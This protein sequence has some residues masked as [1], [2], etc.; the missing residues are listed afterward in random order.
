VQPLSF[1]VATADHQVEAYV[2]GWDD[3]RD[4]WERERGLDR[5]GRATDFW[6]YFSDDITKARELGCRHFRLSLSWSRL[7][8]TPG[9]YCPE[10]VA[11]Y[12][13]ILEHIREQG[14][15]PIVTLLH[16]TWPRH[17]E[18]RGGL[19][20][21]GFPLLFAAF[22]TKIAQ[23][24]ARLVRLWVT[25]NEPTQLVYG[26]IKPAFEAEYAAPPG[27][28]P[29][30]SGDEQALQVSSLIRNLFCAHK[31]AREAIRKVRPS[32][33]VGANPLVLGMPG[34]IRWLGECRVQR[35]Q[36]PERVRTHLARIGTRRLSAG[37]RLDIVLGAYTR[38]HDREREVAFSE[39]Y[40]IA[41]RRILVRR[42]DEQSEP[43]KRK[44]APIA[45]L[46]G[47]T[48]E[49]YLERSMP[50]V[51]GVRFA[52]AFSALEALRKGK[53]DG[54][55]SDDVL[56]APYVR[57][58]PFELSRELLGPE[59][60]CVA[61]AKRHSDLLMPI[62]RVLHARKEALGHPCEESHPTYVGTRPRSENPVTDSLRKLR[63]RGYLRVGLS[64]ARSELYER[65]ESRHW[66]GC[67]PDLARALAKEL[68]G[69]N[70]TVRFKQR[71]IRQRARSLRP[72]WIRALD[73]L[74]NYYVLF[75]LIAADWWSMGMAGELPESLCPI[76]CR[77]EQDYAGLDYYWGIA[78]PWPT[79]VG[80]LLDAARGHFSRAPVWPGGLAHVL[81]RLASRFPDKPIYV[82][83]NGCVDRADGVARESYLRS[84]IDQVRRARAK[85]I[86]VTIYTC[87][88]ITTNREWGFP[89]G[90]DTDF[91]L[92]RISLDD[93]RLTRNPT[94][95]SGAY[96][97]IIRSIT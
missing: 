93:P 76:E 15:E 5:R 50:M 43:S 55:L 16:F 33:E 22:A 24:Y 38:S 80:R 3:I 81:K 66:T 72:W 60:Y 35:L 58:G 51:R 64:G 29:G 39:P 67:E 79:R 32:A 82:M 71:S 45:V 26:F 65:T 4:Q 31:A 12:R 30:T 41:T 48:S 36:G 9:V 17:V 73:A 57:D 94:A 56:L 96:E 88:S 25:F 97:T 46:R 14:M 68:I 89:A 18:Q 86:K 19:T 54:W 13:E 6:R 7:E 49:A 21:S 52:D 44:G 53:V 63:K 87:W 11:K 40:H 28:P 23:E 62:T 69:A 90:P 37:G 78:C 92:F 85:G 27:L 83:E 1:G 42:G 95:S 91:G 74:E 20:A 61:V 8:P 2:E 84:H 34:W 70:A 77:G 10:V 75:G 47:S 59:P